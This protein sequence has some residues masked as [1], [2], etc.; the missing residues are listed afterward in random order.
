RNPEEDEIE[1]RVVEGRQAG[2]RQDRE[3]GDAEDRRGLGNCVTGRHHHS[4]TQSRMA[5]STEKDTTGAQAGLRTAMA[6]DSLAP[7]SRP[8]NSAPSGLPSRPMIT[9]AKTTPS[10][11]QIWAGARVA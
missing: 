1:E 11:A 10:H 2:R 3:D 9:T 8:A 4:G 5:I 6:I 7:I